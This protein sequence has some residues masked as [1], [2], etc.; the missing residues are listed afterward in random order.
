MMEPH[1]E[2]IGGPIDDDDDHIPEEIQ[3]MMSLTNAMMGPPPGLFGGR[4]SHGGGDP[5]AQILKQLEE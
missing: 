2:I 5:L 1:I 3:H 4:I